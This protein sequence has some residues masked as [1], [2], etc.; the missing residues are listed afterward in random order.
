[1]AALFLSIAFIFFSGVSGTGKTHIS[2]IIEMIVIFFYLIIA[3]ILADLLRLEIQYVWITEC[4][5]SISLGI[6]S[7]LYLKYGKW[8]SSMV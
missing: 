2:F 1:V 5:Y 4:F 7:F 3:Y 6:L 8:K